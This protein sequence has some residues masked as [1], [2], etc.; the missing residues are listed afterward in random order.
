MIKERHSLLSCIPRQIDAQQS[1]PCTHGTPSGLQHPQSV[2]YLEQLDRNMPSA[3][4]VPFAF[5]VETVD[6]HALWGCGMAGFE[7]QR[8]L[9]PGTWLNK[10]WCKLVAGL[11]MTCRAAGPNQGRQTISERCVRDWAVTRRLADWVGRGHPDSSR[12]YA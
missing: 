3:L 6:L 9:Q 12:L 1:A 11:P 8:V 4:I 5:V 7:H 2:S 10:Q